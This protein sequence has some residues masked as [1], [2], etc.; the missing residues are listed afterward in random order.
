[1][2]YADVYCTSP[3]KSG[4]EEDEG[5]TLDVLDAEHASVFGYVEGEACEL[6]RVGFRG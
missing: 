3:L 1:M 6:T 2:E 5:T 4:P